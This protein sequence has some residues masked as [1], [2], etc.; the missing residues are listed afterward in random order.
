MTTPVHAEAPSLHGRMIQLD[1]LRGVAILLVLVR[2]S[3]VPWS[4]AGVARPA[5]LVL[6]RLGWTGVDLFFV[7][8]GFLIGGLLFR[9]IRTTGRLDVRRFLV[10]RGLK[11]WPAYLVYVAF[12]FCVVAY[13]TDLGRS[14]RAILPNLL[15]VQN[16]FGTPR[17]QT[18]SLAVEEHFYLALPLFLLLLLG[19]GRRRGAIIVGIPATAITLIFVCTTL[20]VALNSHKTFEMFTDQ[21]ATHLRID[22]LFFGVLIAYLY[23]LRP[24]IMARI[25][26]HRLILLIVGLAIISPMALY[27]LSGRAYIWTIGF[28]LLYVGYGMILIAFV[29]T[30]PGN[31]IA[32]KLISSRLAR[33]V[34]WIGVFS[35]SIYLWQLD[36]AVAPV[37][38]WVLPHL[39]HH[40]LTLLWVLGWI[41]YLVLA[42]VTG[43]IA[44]KLIEIPALAIRDRLFPARVAGL[45]VRRVTPSA[46]LAASPAAES[47][48][49]TTPG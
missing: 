29:H 30:T 23:H 3:P 12:V 46:S 7:L 39:P 4:Y 2:H 26:R 33:F 18:W 36:L 31:G 13:Q 38:R 11:I 45:A 34:A 41:A 35:Y 14:F 24:E 44:A 32:G 48:F 19:V 43:V 10:R 21:T 47:E 5:M 25:G 27:D 28:T 40:P 16:Y 8:S 15:H 22:G 1:V 17:G 49:S 6:W 20:R 42:V 37:E 9:E